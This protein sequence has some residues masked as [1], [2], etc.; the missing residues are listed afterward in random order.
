MGNDLELSAEDLEILIRDCD[1]SIQAL[2]KLEWDLVFEL[3]NVKKEIKSVKLEKDYLRSLQQGHDWQAPLSE[4]E[5][6]KTQIIGTLTLR[7][8]Q[9]L[10]GLG[11]HPLHEISNVND[12]SIKC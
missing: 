9:L 12:D 3:R 6:L 2:Q 4:N 5:E 1:E 11:R 10:N 7:L 8:R